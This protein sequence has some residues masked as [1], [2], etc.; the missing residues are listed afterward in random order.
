MKVLL[1]SLTTLF[2]LAAMSLFSRDQTP[3]VPFKIIE[4]SGNIEIRSYD[5]VLMA[6]VE[7]PGHM[8]EIGS[9]GFRELAAYIFGGNE[10][11]QKIAMTA[12]VNFIETDSGKTRMSFS[13][14]EGLQLAGM[15]KPLS[16]EIQLHEMSPRKLAVLRFGGFAGNKS[17]QEKADELRNWLRMKNISW[18]EPVIFM[19]YNSPWTL[20]GRRNEVAF[21]LYR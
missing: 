8:M 12:P 11:S 18:K 15:P 14:P 17:I 19:A 6:S 3:Q 10:R 7:K 9:P 2:I 1:F 21:E 5:P 16:K 20:I 4:Q 13:M